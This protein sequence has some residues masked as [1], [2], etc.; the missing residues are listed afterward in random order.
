MG[1]WEHHWEV[2]NV[3]SVI[4]YGFVQTFWVFHGWVACVY[5]TQTLFMLCIVALRVSWPAH[6]RA[7]RCGSVVRGFFLVVVTLWD[8]HYSWTCYSFALWTYGI[9]VENNIVAQYIWYIVSLHIVISLA[10]RVWL[11]A[12]PL[13]LGLRSSRYDAAT[14]YVGRHS[15]IHSHN[16]CKWKWGWSPARMPRRTNHRSRR[17]SEGGGMTG[18]SLEL[19]CTIDMILSCRD[20]QG[21]KPL[22]FDWM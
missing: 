4:V 20:I 13:P 2:L 16:L 18:S 1:I 9:T 21:K 12:L 14:L 6:C 7:W 11:S 10:G 22:L 8:V 15:F 5:V 19:W 17:E 3:T